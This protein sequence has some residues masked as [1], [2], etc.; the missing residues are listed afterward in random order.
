MATER[1]RQQERKRPENERLGRIRR[2]GSLPS[3]SAVF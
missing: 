3:S 2:A 1:D